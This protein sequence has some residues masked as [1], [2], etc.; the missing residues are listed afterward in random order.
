MKEPIPEEVRARCSDTVK[1]ALSMEFTSSE[2][3]A[4]LGR[5]DTVKEIVPKK[6]N[7]DAK[8]FLFDPS[9]LAFHWTFSCSSST[10]FKTA[11][12]AKVP[13]QDVSDPSPRDRQ[14]QAGGAFF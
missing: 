8:I 5:K 1:R 9:V 4:C 6:L 13:W 3:S 12:K 10:G 11:T 2:V 7:E 14:K